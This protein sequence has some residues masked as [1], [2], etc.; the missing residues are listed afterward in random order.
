M[1]YL[2]QCFK[3]IYFCLFLSKPRKTNRAGY[4]H[5]AEITIIPL[6]SI[7]RVHEL[8]FPELST[9]TNTTET[10]PCG[11]GPGSCELVTVTSSWELSL[12]IGS[13]QVTF[14]YWSFVMNV[15]GATQRS[16]RG[17]SLSVIRT[18]WQNEFKC[19]DNKGAQIKSA[20]TV[21]EVTVDL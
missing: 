4:M 20:N 15:G 19:I 5:S 12:K 13:S 17:G 8:L 21:L 11:K 1:K 14:A 10:S 2:F 18:K 9:A 6:T 7:V 16:I 3:Y